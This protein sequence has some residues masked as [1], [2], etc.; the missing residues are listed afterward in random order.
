MLLEVVAS[1]SII[2]VL[3]LHMC[4]CQDLSGACSCV[5]VILK[6]IKIKVLSFQA[7][8]NCLVNESY[9]VKVSDFGMTRYWSMLYTFYG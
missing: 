4:N 8:R 5:D 6:T 1:D 9:V 7:A 2:L 3:S